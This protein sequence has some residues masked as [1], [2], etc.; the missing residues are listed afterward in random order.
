MA[1]KSLDELRQNYKQNNESNSE[2]RPNNY[3]PFWNMKVGEQAIVRFLPDA[4]D[5]NPLGFMVEKVMHNLTIN[6]DRKSVPCLSMYGEDCPVCKVSQAYYKQEDKKNGSK[7]WK[8]KQHLA[9]VLVVEDPLEADKETG[10]THEGKVR[11]LSIGY[12][13]YNVIMEAFDSGDLEERPDHYENGTDF[14]IKKTKQGEYDSY[15]I[16][17]KFARRERALD[18]DT[19]ANLDLIDL[20]TLLPKNLGLD[21][22]ED[23]LNAD[24]GGKAYVDDKKPSAPADNTV[25]KV[26]AAI[27]TAAAVETSEDTRAPEL[28]QSAQDLLEEIRNRRK[29]EAK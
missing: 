17:S 21:K 22:V 5:D 25:A 4:N 23:L 1:F 26:E 11:F 28:E 12:Q 8:K 19:I 27:E 7:Y 15:Q 6:G 16:G 9:Q 29:A 3:Y 20:S 2:S 24:L 14:I 13:L 18:E 10:E